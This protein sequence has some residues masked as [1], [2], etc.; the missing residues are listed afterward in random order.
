MTS[1]THRLIWSS[2]AR[3]RGSFRERH[4]LLG[5]GLLVVAGTAPAAVTPIDLTGPVSSWDII[6]QGTAFDP[7]NDQQASSNPGVDIVGT[8]LDATMLTIYD[9]KG[10]PGD[11]SDDEL[12][13]R[14]RVGGA[15]SQ[16]GFGGNLWIGM[17]VDLDGDLDAFIGMDG[18]GKTGAS[19]DGQVRVYEA[20][21]DLNTSP[22]TSSAINPVWVADLLDNGTNFSFD[23]VD[24]ITDPLRSTDDINLDG[25]TDRFI[26][27]K[28]NWDALKAVL[29]AKPLT[30]PSGN[31]IGSLNGGLGVTKDTAIAYTL[32]TSTNSNNVN[33]D[34]GGYDNKNDDMSVS[35]EDQDAFSPPLSASNIFPV[36][37]SD[38]GGDTATIHIYE[39]ATSVTTVAASDANGDT[40]IYAITGGADAGLF[41]LNGDQLSFISAPVFGVDNE[42]LVIVTADDQRGG[43]DSQILT[44]IVD[45]VTGDVVAPTVT[46][47]MR[48][49]PASELTNADSVTF[50]VTFDEPV[51][52]V[53]AD[54]FVVSGTVAGGSV[55][56]VLDLGGGSYGVTVT[57]IAA[58][59]G[60]LGLAFA[61]T[62]DIADASGNALGNTAP[63]G[64]SETYTLDNQAP[65]LSS[66]EV[67]GNTLTL[68]YDE[69][70]DG[71]SVPS[72]ADFA[73]QLNGGAS[74]TISAVAVTGNTVVLTLS[75]TVADTDTV[76]VSYTG[77]GSPIQDAAANPVADLSGAAVLNNT[78][79]TLAPSVVSVVRL[80]PLTE[81]T[82][83]DSVTFQVVFSEQV[84]NV[85]AD[86]FVA[87]GAAAGTAMISAVSAQSLNT[88]AVTVTGI[89][90]ANGILSLGFAGGQNITDT[91]ANPLSNT[92]P[93]GANESYTLD[94][95][96]PGDALVTAISGD[97][98][99]SS[100]DGV[101]NDQTLIISGSA[102]AGAT[103]EVLLNGSVI[104]SIIANGSGEWTLDYTGAV[105]AE[106]A[107]TLKAQ[108]SDAA[109]NTGTVAA[110][111]F[112]VLVDITDPQMATF[113]EDG[114][115]L[116]DSTPT[117]SG[118]AEPNV[119]VVVSID[120]QQ[121][122][123]SADGAGNWSVTV[124]N[125]LADSSYAVLVTSTDLAGNS[126]QTNG[127][128]TIDST[129]DSDND[130]IPDAVEGTV[131]TDDDNTPDYL[132]TDSDNDGIPDSVEG[133]VDTDN[134]TTPNYRDLDSDNDGKPDADEGTGDV[135]GDGIANYIDADDTD[136][137][138]GDPDGDGLT[139]QQEDD[140]GSNGNEQDT[141]G[142]GKNDGDEVGG[143]T[144][145]P[146]DT[147]GD[148]IPDYV[149]PDDV[150]D[151]A[152]GN[153]SDNDGIADDIEC[154]DYSAG[155]PDSDN[156]GLPDY[157]DDDDDNDGIPTA[158]E[159]ATRDTDGNGIP[160]Y[161]D[162]DDD[163]DGLLTRNEDSNSDM[164][165]DA[166]TNPGPDA[167]SDG[168]P[169]YLD[170]ND[171]IAGV[172]DADGDGL[173]DD[174][175]CGSLPCQDSDDDGV[176]DY[177]DADD[178]N[179][180]INTADEDV[181]GNGDPRD[182]DTDGDGTP[183]YLDTDDDGDGTDTSAESPANDD[184]GDNI[185]NHLDKDSNNSAG[186]ADNSGDSDGDGL[187]DAEECPTGVPCQD[188]DNDGT[189]DYMDED[190][191]GDGINTR[192][193]DL[194]GNGD[195]TDDDSD[196]D[197][198][199]D[200]LD[201]DDDD[202]GVDTSNEG[203]PETDTDG[204]G[205]P[206]YL[207]PDTGDSDG[208]G[209]GDG[210]ECP[211]GVPCP[212]SDGDG[213]S[214]FIDPDDDND[215]INTADEDINGN[216]DPRDDDTDGDG[217]PDYLDTDDDNDGVPSKDEGS[218]D[219][220]GD[221]I[222][223]YV[224]PDSDDSDGNDSDN[225]GLTDSEECPDFTG[226][227]CPD[228]DGDGI[229]DYLDP[230]ASKAASTNRGAIGTGL[231]GAGST[232]LL[233]VLMLLLAGLVRARN[234]GARTVLAL[235][236]LL[237]GLALA[238]QAYLGAG[239]G[240]SWL[241]PDADEAGYHLDD[242]ND[243]SLLVLGGYQWHPH[244]AA[245][246]LYVDLGDAGLEARQAVTP[247]SL[248]VAYRFA[249]VSAM[250]FLKGLEPGEKG[251]DFFARLGGGELEGNAGST[252]EDAEHSSQIYF[253][254]GA[255]HRW[256]SGWALRAEAQSF[257]TDASLVSLAVLKRFGGSGAAEPEHAEEPVPADDTM[258]VVSAPQDS[259]SDGV[260]DGDDQCPDSQANVA[261]D[262]AGCEI[263]QEAVPLDSDGDG[264]SDDKDACPGSEQGEPVDAL[265]CSKS[266][267]LDTRNILFASGSA[268]LTEKG[269][270]A[271][272]NLAAAL[273]DSSVA[274]EVLAYTDSV[275]PA[276][277]NLA[278]SEKRAATVVEELVTL[279][280][281]R[282]RLTAVG[283]GE[284]DPVAD[285]ATA[286][287][288]EA[289]RRVEFKLGDASL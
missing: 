101:T 73:V 136:G 268:A 74:V 51:Q 133:V 29:N 138:N 246:A 24:N 58:A 174:Q 34:V 202:D 11:T 253:G 214:D 187:S 230:L 191:D 155:C 128:V 183:D 28:I 67:I 78:N 9:D 33:A 17:D 89:S 25:N 38:G 198:T 110:P 111:F 199:P 213:F 263:S 192:D 115:T 129:L 142:D 61:P 6:M 170:P 26:S 139:N 123:T 114:D 216:G 159:G 118:T 3:I 201:S 160:D 197:G 225:D 55:S 274:I 94:N 31:L 122:S 117:L 85:S 131:D 97:S 77:A 19:F 127:S 242:K 99:V 96:A 106:G 190:D 264:V 189:P 4:S 271:V 222:P 285:N 172:G 207:D 279:G 104:G 171:G 120:G 16:G 87:S 7:G 147:D 36:I 231:N 188:S 146:N 145:N 180:G 15:N 166:S 125:T 259:D 102:D 265:G 64:A 62:Q 35:F 8:D 289:N 134:D 229:P 137:P 95:L 286:E 149:D 282:Q 68:T 100:S 72:I 240:M 238:G 14:V 63:S 284:T 287:G 255:E 75:A 50:A 270:Q 88:F 178:D 56:G 81:L 261:V 119:A 5:L 124:T 18:D 200:Y 217:T 93:S 237:P 204:D 39:G 30:D 153:D 98:G 241:Q 260:V 79:D 92:S 53:S 48:S 227:G 254:A 256:S 116:V 44:V 108:A 269:K 148:G 2:V 173:T 193:E 54:D 70:L 206:D 205:I 249:G 22:S 283:K 210:I 251:W 185:P 143:D 164:D 281:D 103:V 13:F 278:L 220:D 150:S 167:D 21:N 82:N 105:L 203:G 236:S 65:T 232:P 46:S 132:D 161:L 219:D 141:D 182:D 20:G 243:L 228:T 235:A 176:P 221:G 42:Y 140:L 184:D 245:E 211:D 91:S 288:R 10:T 186:T 277:A 247:A 66:A 41:V 107:Y 208:D 112:N 177:M 83:A 244:W 47:I 168:I 113:A 86:D 32:S 267:A 27:F 162:E 181:N 266:F 223:N 224:D 169:A 23:T 152:N 239:A 248:D 165:D 209:L 57:G 40:V 258:A 151:D 80:N 226:A 12:A 158:T 52:N 218:G 262:A 84:D 275:G 121:Y 45:E 60:T 175:E 71:T 90:D 43:T 144:G 69:T 250:Y 233:S 109:G 195:P 157:L 59:N 130:G 126:S 257:D 196:N 1:H 156:D 276:A 273:G 154:P 215:G 163:G 212:D 272:A 135:D 194:D 280:V 179:D 234:K 49:N 252:E 76:T 37:N